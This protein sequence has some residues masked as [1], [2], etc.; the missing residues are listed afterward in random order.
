MALKPLEKH[1]ERLADQVYD[2][3][4]AAIR[5]GDIDPSSRIVQEK[6]AEELNVSRTPVREALFRM[7]Q[8]GILEVSGKGGFLIRRHT[9][10]EIAELYSSRCAIEGY[11][12]RLL[13]ESVSTGLIDS[14]RRGI[15]QA[16]TI[17]E[18][19]V[20]G[21]FQANRS[22]HR[23]FV[24]AT[25]NRFLLEFFDLI[26]NRGSSYTLFATLTDVDLRQSLGDHQNLVDAIATGDGNVAA[27]RMIDHIRDGHRL[28]VS[29]LAR[30]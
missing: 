25:G 11:S 6:L 22:I 21:Y 3:I 5:S 24:A 1:R 29:A 26:W 17:S 12:A 30:D 13:A 8:E 19:T 23:T 4:M 10:A 15:T 16:E 27:E 14:L 7:E 9:E 18:P 20:M 2:Q 28:Q